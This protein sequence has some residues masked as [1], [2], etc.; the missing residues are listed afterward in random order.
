MLKYDGR[1][2]HFKKR[3]KFSHKFEKKKMKQKKGIKKIKSQKYVHQQFF[4]II[5]H[6]WFCV[7]CK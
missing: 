4:D 6:A 2:L 5:N 3:D 7:T 1:E